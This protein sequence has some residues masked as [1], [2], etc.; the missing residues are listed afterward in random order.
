MAY[1]KQVQNCN[2]I[3]AVTGIVMVSFKIV[4]IVMAQIQLT[5]IRKLVERKYSSEQND[6]FIQAGIPT[7]KPRSIPT[8]GCITNFTRQEL[9]C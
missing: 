1:F 2:G 5:L 6:Q 7:N 3:S 4:Q 8:P 9:I